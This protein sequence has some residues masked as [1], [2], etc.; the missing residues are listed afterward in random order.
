MQI[1]DI[2]WDKLSEHAWRVRDNSYVLGKTKVGAALLSENGKIFSGCNIEHK[3]RSHDIHAEVNAISNMVA[4][5]E[6]KFIAIL[7]VADRKLFTPCGSCM[8]WIMQ[9]GDNNCFVGFENLQKEKTIFKANELM[10]FYP[11]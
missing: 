6:T 8:D 10:P 1:N 5:G 3:Y 7:I 11:K 2:P 9:H 4:A